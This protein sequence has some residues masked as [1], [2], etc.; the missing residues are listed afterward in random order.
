MILL[1]TL[2]M[3]ILTEIPISNR[4]NEELSEVLNSFK[5]ESSDGTAPNPDQQIPLQSSPQEP[6][7]MS[8]SLLVKKSGE[9]EWLVGVY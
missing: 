9:R 1:Y 5:K 8:S 2:L 7:L 6:D 3:T 4:P